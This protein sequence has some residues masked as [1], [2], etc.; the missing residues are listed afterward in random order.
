MEE[1]EN[2]IGYDLRRKISRTKQKMGS[3]FSMTAFNDPDHYGT[4]EQKEKIK[5]MMSGVYMSDIS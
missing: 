1:V 4:Q 3:T 5:Q 2:H